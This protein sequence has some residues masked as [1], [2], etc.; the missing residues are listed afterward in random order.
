[1]DLA[2][3]IH[4]LLD[5]FLAD[6]VVHQVTWHQQTLLA[7]LLDH[8]LGLLSILL[9]LR[10]VANRN[11]T[12]FP[13]EENC[14]CTSN[15]GTMATGSE[16]SRPTSW[17]DL[18][19]TSNEGFISLQLACSEVFLE[20]ILSFELGRLARRFHI[21]L[22]AITTDQ[23][24]NH[25]LV[26]GWLTPASSEIGA[27]SPARSCLSDSSTWCGMFWSE[28]CWVLWSVYWKVLFLVLEDKDISR[29]NVRTL[30]WEGMT[31]ADNTRGQPHFGGTFSIWEQ[32]M[33]LFSNT[34]AIIHVPASAA[35]T[36]F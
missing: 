34:T 11:I 15:A 6:L 27:P 19:S 5:N 26:A 7:L 32:V 1:M 22:Q 28:S 25:L 20:A 21:L 23:K 12:T 36:S 24:M 33:S 14:D 30:S 17:T 9:L 4:M 29:L 8:P 13:R 2:E 18:L 16:I 3:L 35:K 31:L 10:Q